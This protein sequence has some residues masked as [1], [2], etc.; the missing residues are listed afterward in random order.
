MIS[1]YKKLIPCAAGLLFAFTTNAQIVEGTVKDA[2]TGETL[3]YVNVGIVGKSIG[4]VTNQDGKFKLDLKGSTADTLKLSMIGYKP[5]AFITGSYSTGKVIALQPDVVN[6]K[7]VKVKPKKWKTALLGNQTNSKSG[8]AGFTSNKLGNEIG[9]I[10]KI[11]KS[12]TLIKKFFANVAMEPQDS[13][14][15]RLNFYSVKDG[16][17]DQLLNT[18]NIFVTLKKGQEQIALDLEPYNI[19]A[20]DKFVVT[21]EWIEN[22]RGQGV[23][24]SAS[25]FKGPIIARETSQADWEKVGMFG[26]GFYVLAEY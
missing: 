20:E 19:I 21:L 14:K 24:F 25:F 23:H 2:K 5:Q 4:T 8:N 11:K 16:L 15:M 6:L 10:I 18:R 9:T 22:A 7:E 17:P 12:P 1:V 3:P 26:L 13:V